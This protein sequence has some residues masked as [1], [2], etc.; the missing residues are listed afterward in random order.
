MPNSSKQQNIWT[1]HAQYIKT[2]KYMN[3]ACPI[4][5]NNKIYEL[6]MPNTSKQQNIWTTHAQY[7]KTTKY[8]NY[9]CPIHQNNKIY[10]LRMPNTSKQQNIWTTHAQYIKTT[11][12]HKY[13]ELFFSKYCFTH[14]LTCDTFETGGSAWPFSSRFDILTSFPL[15]INK[16][17]INFPHE[18][19]RF[20]P[21]WFHVT[22]MEQP[23]K[24]MSL[25]WNTLANPCHLYGT[26]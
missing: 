3:Y 10:E 21:W 22:Y 16:H 9:A 7:I 6:R 15:F 11:I 1:T 14:C 20:A 12:S 25:I 17:N 18:P 8:M 5:Q 19:M 4:H 23:S 26:P 2:T 24:S 13:M